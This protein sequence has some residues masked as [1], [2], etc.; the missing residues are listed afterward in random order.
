VA[1][2]S[3]KEDI[4]YHPISKQT[5]EDIDNGLQ[6]GGIFLSHPVPP[7]RLDGRCLPVTIGRGASTLFLRK[8]HSF[9]HPT[10]G[11]E[12]E[13]RKYGLIPSPEQT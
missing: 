5:L 8:N 6:L 11:L 9:R 10:D 4:A 13:R 7:A 1:D 3:A 12:T 2:E